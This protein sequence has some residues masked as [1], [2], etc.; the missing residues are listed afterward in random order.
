MPRTQ[1]AKTGQ[2]ADIEQDNGTAI[3][4]VKKT[5]VRNRQENFGQENVEPGDNSR[6]L[7]L[8]RVALDLP[9]I[10]ISDPKQVERRINEYLDFCEQNDMKPGLVKMATWLGVDQRTLRRWK[11][12]DFREETHCPMIK[13]TVMALEGLWEDYMDNGK[14]NPG[15]GIFIGKNHF[16]YRD[17]IDLAPTQAAP[18][19]ELIDRKALEAKVQDDVIVDE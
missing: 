19:G 5:W 2:K 10:D 18:M 3:E 15:S 13:K 11:T 1:K 6:Y 4:K 8:A 16:G 9:P 14:I 12:G 7:R 17:V